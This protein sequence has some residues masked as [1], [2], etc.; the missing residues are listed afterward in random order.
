MKN[1]QTI[2]TII[3]GFA[4]ALLF[5]LVANKKTP[6]TAMQRAPQSQH[7]VYSDSTMQVFP[8]AYVNFDSLMQNYEYYKILEKQYEVLVKK[9]ETILQQKAAAFEK[10]VS[11]FQYNAQNGLITSRAAET[12]QMELQ[13]KQEQLVQQQQAKGAEL[14]HHEQ[15]L[16]V[17]LLDSVQATIKTY[18]ADMRFKMILNNAAILD[19][20]ESFN[21]TQDV[22]SLMNER[23][24]K[25][26]KK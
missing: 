1:S 3:F 9:E 26:I 14:A 6:E 5:I 15:S 12:K 17:Q 22:L 7:I 16:M 18:N 25:S 2:I 19:A 4:I 24:T 21:I 20:S 13:K 23:Y 8:I 10:E 11:E